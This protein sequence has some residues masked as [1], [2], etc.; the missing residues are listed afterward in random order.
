MSMSVTHEELMQLRAHN[1]FNA[2]VSLSSSSNSN[3]LNFNPGPKATNHRLQAQS[4][5]I[6]D[7]DDDEK[8]YENEEFEEEEVEQY[9]DEG[10]F[11][12][13]RGRHQNSPGFYSYSPTS[14]SSGSSFGRVPDSNG[15]RRSHK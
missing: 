15:S 7:E 9:N 8:K 3:I 5:C 2:S 6:I 1:P 11:D 13:R 14:T 4:K 12:D 10:K